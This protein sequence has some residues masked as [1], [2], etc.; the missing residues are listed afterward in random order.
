[1]TKGWEK[2]LPRQDK[3][4]NQD[5]DKAEKIMGLVNWILQHM[6][7]ILQH[8]YCIIA[9]H[10]STSTFAAHLQHISA[11]SIILII[12]DKVTSRVW[13][14]KGK[15]K[16]KIEMNE[17]AV[18]AACCSRQANSILFLFEIRIRFDQSYVVNMMSVRWY[19]L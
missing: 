5:K 4:R 11:H 16:P 13:I 18:A 8:M 14:P 1:M 15:S 12:T 9:A 7:C 19:G 2:T 17:L 10:F 3:D 6:C